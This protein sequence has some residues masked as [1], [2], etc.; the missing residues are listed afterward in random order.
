[1]VKTVLLDRFTR[2]LERI[3]EFGER[4]PIEKTVMQ[5]S[6]VVLQDRQLRWCDL[7]DLQM[8]PGGTEVITS[9]GLEH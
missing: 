7:L 4:A 3:H 6:L 8:A 5:P 1:M 9:R 2:F